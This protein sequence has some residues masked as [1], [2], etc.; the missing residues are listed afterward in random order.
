MATA[1]EVINRLAARGVT[2]QLE[3]SGGLRINGISRLTDREKAA[4]RAHKGALLKALA[5]TTATTAGSPTT[6][7]TE[8]LPN[9]TTPPELGSTAPFNQEALDAVKAGAGCWVWSGVLNEWLFM[10][11]DEERKAKA[12]SRGIDP[13]CIWTLAEVTG[14]Q[15][16]PPEGLRD[17]AAIK[18]RFA[19]AVQPGAM[20]AQWRNAFQ[21][22]EPAVTVEE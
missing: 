20:P 13:G 8:P 18:R 6:A 1:T 12:M 11:R 2:F 21:P 7:A 3:A 22:L 19:G 10:V 16:M 14:V 15:G 4:L 5:S 9:R 17:V